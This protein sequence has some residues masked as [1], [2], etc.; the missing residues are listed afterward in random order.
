MFDLFRS[1]EKS[2]RIVLGG[3]LLMV[4]VS[5]LTYL[6][7]SYGT[8]NESPDSVV[9][10]VGNKDITVGDVKKV[11][12]NVLKQ[13]QFPA[14]ILPNYI[15]R[16]VDEMITERALEYEAG[17]LGFQVTD[18]DVATTVRQMLPPELFPDGK[19][20]G[21]EIYASFLAQRDMTIE[22][23]ESDVRRQILIQRLKKVAVEGTI[24]SDT[25]I[26]ETFKGRNAK[27]KIQYVK[28]VADKYNKEVEPTVDELKAYFTPN[29]A[30]YQDPAKKNLAV[31][32]IDQAKLEQSINPSDNELQAMYRQ[33]QEQFR[34][35][36]RIKVRHILLKTQGKPAGEDAKLK[37]QADDLLKQIKGGASFADLVEKYSDDT[38]SKANAPNR[39]P[40]LGPG[41]YYVEKDSQM[42]AEFKTAAFALKPGESE[43]VKS[44]IG[45]HVM[46][47]VDHQPARLKPF[48]EVKADLLKQWK[49]Q[50]SNAIL[51]NASDKAEVQLKADP[52]HPE[53][54]AADLNMQ[55]VRVDNYM[56][57]QPMGELGLSPDLERAVDPLKKGEVSQMVT[58]PLNRIGLAVVTDIIP[59]R[60]KSF[61][62][63][64]ADMRKTMIQ[65]RLKIA[66]QKHAQELYDKAKEM[67]GDL[68]KAARSMGQ[69]V[70]TSEEFT[71]TGSV[72]DLDSANYFQQGFQLPDGAV[73][74]PIPLVSGTVVAKVIAHIPADMSQLPAERSKI[75]DDIKSKRA[76]DRDSLFE[77]GVVTELERTGK[78]KK[79]K[80][81]IDRLIT[82]YRG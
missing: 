66:L 6:V 74:G 3:I 80:A 55:M 61:E 76:T 37:A 25:E 62:E 47:V 67:N 30:N 33:N 54:V 9:A 2:V 29:A 23:F 28:L 10:Q 78:L 75:R 20:L 11:I 77:A 8:G 1:R 14:E 17:R 38:G 13:K 4:A 18:Q 79:N 44:V 22:E 39:E 45:Y 5:M 68:E 16:L 35:P 43:V 19:F 40:G 73:Y 21:K 41:E 57:G 82:A 31:L 24:V 70:K 36:E 15:P 27:I 12:Q 50:R 59:P 34:V 51:Q 48:E 81:V 64:Q 49:S 52:L 71:R 53:K 60:Q 7:P 72:K 56:V 65:A 26:V 69:E 42:V 58:L 32:Y 46:Q 63:A